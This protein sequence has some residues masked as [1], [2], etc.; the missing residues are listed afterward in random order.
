[1]YIYIYLYIYIYTTHHNPFPASIQLPTLR[2]APP[3]PPW[4]R[5]CHALLKLAVSFRDL[6][7][8]DRL[9]LGARGWAGMPIGGSQR[10]MCY[11]RVKCVQIY[12]HIQYHIEICMHTHLRSLHTHTYLYNCTY[13]HVHMHV[14][15]RLTETCLLCQASLFLRK[16]SQTTPVARF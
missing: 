10:P 15:H 12:L 11:R 4:A 2:P 14:R 6:L 3:L 13:I 1:M 9:P 5:L 16:S 7:L 8:S